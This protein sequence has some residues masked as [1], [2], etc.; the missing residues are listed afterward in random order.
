MYYLHTLI[1][2]VSKST[3]NHHKHG[4]PPPKKKK[5]T[6]GKTIKNVC[7]ESVNEPNHQLTLFYQLMISVRT[8]LRL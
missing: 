1:D 8:A 6:K 3:L 2:C 4:P 7:S 5:R